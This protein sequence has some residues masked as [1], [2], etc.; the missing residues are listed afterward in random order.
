MKNNDDAEGVVVGYVSGRKTALGS[1]LLGFMGALILDYQGKR[2]E[3]SGFTNEERR[4]G[5]VG[6]LCDGDAARHRAARYPGD[7]VPAWIETVAFPRGSIVTFVYR[8][9][10]KDG[11]PQEA[12]YLRKKIAE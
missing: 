2:L 3:L 4:L 11:I 1:K 9:L 7:E 8:G 12:R 10:S 5:T 6:K